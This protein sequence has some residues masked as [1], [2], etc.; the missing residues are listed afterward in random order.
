MALSAT[1]K[2]IQRHTFGNVGTISNVTRPPYMSCADVTEAD[3]GNG[4]GN[5][6]G[7]QSHVIWKSINSPS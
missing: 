6:N 5:G 4:N 2:S 7:R 3:I 1:K